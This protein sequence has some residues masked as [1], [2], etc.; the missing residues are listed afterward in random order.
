MYTNMSEVAASSLVTRPGSN[1]AHS[2]IG[3]GHPWPA[4]HPQPVMFTEDLQRDDPLVPSLIGFE[5]TN[6]AT[7]IGTCLRVSSQLI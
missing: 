5:L 4:G 6:I 7:I 3:I 2:S 1:V